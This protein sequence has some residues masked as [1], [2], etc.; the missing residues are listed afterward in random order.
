VEA[1]PYISDY[2]KSQFV[3]DGFHAVPHCGEKNHPDVS[4]NALQI[5]KF[6]YFKNTAK[7]LYVILNIVHTGNGKSRALAQIFATPYKPEN[8]GDSGRRPMLISLI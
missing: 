3:G 5:L 2:L 1:R 4:I 6:A 8:G 7:N